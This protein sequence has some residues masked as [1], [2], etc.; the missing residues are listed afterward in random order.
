MAYPVR[1]RA[2]IDWVP[3]LLD[4][5]VNLHGWCADHHTVDPRSWSGGE[6]PTR[7]PT[8][9][10]WYWRFANSGDLLTLPGSGGAILAPRDVPLNTDSYLTPCNANF[11]P[12]PWYDADTAPNADWAKKGHEE[13]NHEVALFTPDT[14][15][16]YGRVRT[17]GVEPP[18]RCFLWWYHLM[19]PL[20]VAFWYKKP[21]HGLRLHM[22]V[23]SDVPQLTLVMNQPHQTNYSAVHW[24]LWAW[25]SP[26]TYRLLDKFEQPTRYATQ[27][28]WPTF[29]WVAIMPIN[30]TL[31][32]QHSMSEKTWQ[33]RPP[34]WDPENPAASGVYVRSGYNAADIV[35]TRGWVK[36][37]WRTFPTA[38]EVTGPDFFYPSWMNFTGEARLKGETSH[39]DNPAGDASYTGSFVEVDVPTRR[40]HCKVAVTNNSALDT[41]YMGDNQTIPVG[42]G[43][44]RTPVIFSLQEI[45]RPTVTTPSPVASALEEYGEHLSLSWEEHGRGATGTLL[46]R[47]WE[48]GTYDYELGPLNSYK[49]IGR[50]TIKFAH[51]Y[52]TGDSAFLQIFDGYVTEIK[53]MRETENQIWPQTQFSLQDRSFLWQG[54][55][56]TMI[57]LPDV[58]GWDFKDA[59]SLLLE[60]HGA[61][62]SR[63]EVVY[64]AD[65]ATNP[66]TIPWQVGSSSLT[67]DPMANLMDVLDRLCALCYMR[68]YID[69]FGRVVFDW[70]PKVV[71][72][73]DWTLDEDTV[74]DVDVIELPVESTQ[75]FTD[76]FSVSFARGRSRWG[77]ETEAL[78]NY[79]PAL[80]DTDYDGFLGRKLWAATVE[81]DNPYP[82]RTAQRRLLEGQ[83]RGRSLTWRTL[84]RNLWPGMVVAV[85]V[86]H[87]A[88]P[89]G[90][91]FKVVSKTSEFDMGVH[92]NSLLWNDAYV[93]E[94][95][96][97]GVSV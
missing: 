52:S 11:D 90:T 75:A 36:Y 87:L 57:H 35:G 45:H 41:A 77:E 10:E 12:T 32:I 9:G 91:W 71:S 55:R 48:Y 73:P 20:E 30:G 13:W 64:P 65:Y 44:R 93:G 54:E 97:L 63:G 19:V 47:N 74:T 29:G 24:T 67:F 92:P 95:I 49:G 69:T 68:W 4:P 86:D 46:C 59:T 50:V 33:Y 2:D 34:V 88:V 61:A 8:P 22:G 40:G 94:V 78:Y 56:A 5:Q 3:P 18:D 89:S 76:T 1:S 70:S 15:L 83:Q 27:G 96:R 21:E 37:G 25:T 62:E 81:P 31:Y 28:I 51:Q 38:T 58:A 85:G 84:G 60:H 43:S 7:P 79:T 17:Q 80:T 39:Y 82:G 53:R 26:T 16:N 72:G 14:V 6:D 66:Q 23:Q 42:V